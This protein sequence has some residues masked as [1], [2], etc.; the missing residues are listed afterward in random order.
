MKKIVVLMAASMIFYNGC[1]VGRIFG[2]LAT[3]THS[4]KKVPA[5]YRLKSHKF[6]SML[7]FVEQP[8]WLAADVNIRHHLTQSIK[9]Q[10]CQK[11]NIAE[12]SVVSY[13]ELSR[14]RT[15]TPGSAMFTPV[16]LG[17]ALNADLLLLVT[18][19]NYQLQKLPEADYYRGSLSASAALLD[20]NSGRKLWPAKDESKTVKVGFDVQK[21]DPGIAVSRL[22]GACAHCIVRYLYDCPV[23]NFKIADDQSS[24]SWEQ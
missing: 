7:I 18:I 4:E 2:I 9:K 8:A 20:T 22:F 13:S 5:E 12:A 23:N 1:D 21:G 6:G 14:F 10:L 3:P 11:L 15:G 16:R 17:R 19:E 24:I